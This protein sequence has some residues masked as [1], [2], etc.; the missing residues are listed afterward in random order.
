MQINPAEISSVL[1]KKIAEFDAKTTSY[2]EGIVIGISDGIARI[3]GL[4]KAASYEMLEFDGGVYGIALNL[5][6][7]SVGAVIFRRL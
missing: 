2:N 4:E 6:T 1:K 3:Y 5:E 7:D